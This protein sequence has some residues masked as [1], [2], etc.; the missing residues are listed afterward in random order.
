MRKIMILWIAIPFFLMSCGDDGL[1]E[2]YTVPEPRI[3][4]VRTEDPE[5]RPGDSVS[6]R[7]LMAGKKINQMM[8]NEVEWFLE[9]DPPVSLGTSVYNQD[10]ITEIPMG[11]L[12]EDEDLLDVSI[13]AEIVVDNKT[14]FARKQMRITHDPVAKNPVITEIEV[15]YQIGDDRISEF[16]GNGDVIF[17][18]DQIGEV[19]FT[20]HTGELA[21][22]ENE[23]LIY[24]WYAA[25]AK[26]GEGRIYAYKDEDI[27]EKLLGEGA[28][29][30]ESGRSVV[31]S[32][33]GDENEGNLE[34][35]IYDVYL[36]VRDN[37]ADSQ[38]WE[39]DRFGTDF[40]WFTLCVNKDC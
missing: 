31:F 24:R 26:Q 29:P 35:G 18:G 33:K 30:S 28:E 14:F 4:A 20:T 32:L 8:S 12:S 1:P 19:S 21:E 34:S 11:I 13:I 23:R 39:E 17:V 25:D 36:V 22:G 5:V 37:A 15:R 7:M 3:L 27:T 10:F 40:I 6:M 9:N 16:I 38:S 2:G